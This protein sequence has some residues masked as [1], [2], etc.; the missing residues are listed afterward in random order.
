MQE[1]EQGARLFLERERWIWILEKD[2]EGDQAG[3]RG[4]RQHRRRG[5][6]E[7]SIKISEERGTREATML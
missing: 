5:C 2:E 6:R 4:A 1:H 7:K 3:K